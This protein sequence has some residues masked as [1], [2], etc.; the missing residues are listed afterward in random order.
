VQTAIVIFLGIILLL[1]VVAFLRRGKKHK[2]S[3]G[4]AVNTNP[5]LESR[6]SLLGDNS[7]RIKK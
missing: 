1:L 7:G 5:E 6:Y 2:P 4:N 3:G